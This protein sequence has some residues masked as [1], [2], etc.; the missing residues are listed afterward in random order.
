MQK[1]FSTINIPTAFHFHAEISQE[2]AGSYSSWGTLATL[3][4]VSKL[5]SPERSFLSPSFKPPQQLQPLP[6]QTLKPLPL[7]VSLVKGQPLTSN[8]K[9]ESVS[10]AGKS[11]NVGNDAVA[12]ST[13]HANVQPPTKSFDSMSSVTECNLPN[14]SALSVQQP[15]KKLFDGF[16]DFS[17]NDASKTV[18]VNG[19]RNYEGNPTSKIFESAFDPSIISDLS[20]TK[21]QNDKQD[22]FMSDENFLPILTLLGNKCSEDLTNDLIEAD[23]TTTTESLDGFSHTTESFNDTR[24]LAVNVNVPTVVEKHLPVTLLPN[25]VTE[26]SS[27]LSGRA[28]A[29]SMITTAAG[30]V[31]H[32]FGGDPADDS[33]ANG[34]KQPENKTL[35]KPATAVGK[36]SF[37]DD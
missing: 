21:Q 33:I 3:S 7:E 26:S 16:A 14:I 18:S 5:S 24:E 25:R 11:V 32:I 4:G 10:V 23:Y 22:M 20:G 29:L 17:L 2:S 15:P 8:A 35:G 6:D 19:A 34:L 13:F 27:A 37:F 12:D 1:Y 9:P 30:K 36:L 28:H 31:D